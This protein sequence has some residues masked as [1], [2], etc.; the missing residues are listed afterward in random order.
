MELTSSSLS[1]NNTHALW[2]NTVDIGNTV[3]M[4]DTAQIRMDYGI[5]EITVFMLVMIRIRQ[6][7]QEM[8]GSKLCQ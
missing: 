3:N 1:C 8:D 2:V 4:E 5:K 6:A 7:L